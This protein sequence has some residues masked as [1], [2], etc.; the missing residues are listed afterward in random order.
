MKGGKHP[1]KNTI[2]VSVSE[3]RSMVQDIRRTGKQY[4]ELCITDP[5]DDEE[6]P[7]PTELYARAFDS[8]ECIE[9][10]CIYAPDNESELSDVL[11]QSA[12]RISSN[13]L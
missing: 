2:I 1:M 7:Y 9:F 10:D 4:V 13:L 5:S 6:E 11:S 3:L 8:S 12:L